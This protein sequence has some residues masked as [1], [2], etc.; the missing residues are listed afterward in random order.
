MASQFGADC[1]F[2]SYLE[3]HGR[4]QCWFWFF[5]ARASSL[6]DLM[7]IGIDIGGTFT[8]VVCVQ[9]DGTITTR[10]VLSSVEDYSRSVSATLPEILQTTEVA[11][12][13]V[14]EVIHGTTVAT[15]AILEQSGRADCADHHSKAFV[16]SWNCGVFACRS[17]I[18][19]TGTSLRIWWS[20]SCV[21]RFVSESSRAGGS[22]YPWMKKK[23]LG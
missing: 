13:S 2:S 5:S 7:R 6:Y 22:W 11:G 8:D 14:R 23:L 16:T 4:F 20:G 18:T 15:N 12:S 10:K 1:W 3:T 9:E 19:G 21:G 17:S